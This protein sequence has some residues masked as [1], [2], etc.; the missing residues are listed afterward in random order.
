[1]VENKYIDWSENDMLEV[2]LFEPDDFLK[3]KET[4]TRIGIASIK[5]DFKPALIQS[6]HIL[7]KRGKYYIVHF[8]EMFCLDGKKSKLT[9]QDIIRRNSIAILLE[10]WGMLEISSN[11]NKNEVV[12]MSHIKVVPYREKKNWDL[13]AKY[14]IGK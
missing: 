3:I 11:I 13:I 5:E 2:V 9:S 10:N 6:C 8:K 14:R 12:P 4:L 7:H 1:M